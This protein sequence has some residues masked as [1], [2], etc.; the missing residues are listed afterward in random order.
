MLRHWSQLVP[1]MSTDIKDIKQHYLP[2][3]DSPSLIG[4][5]TSV[6][7]IIIIV[8]VVVIHSFYIVL[9]S[10]LEQTHCARWHVILNE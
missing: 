1:N 3:E 9:I 2:T 8:V 10:A 4:L 7:V 6:D 5:L